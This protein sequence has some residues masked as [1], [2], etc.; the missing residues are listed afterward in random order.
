MDGVRGTDSATCTLPHRPLQSICPSALGASSRFMHPPA[1]MAPASVYLLSMSLFDLTHTGSCAQSCCCGGHGCLACRTSTS[2][3]RSSRWVGVG[4][5]AAGDWDGE[6]HVHVSGQL[7]QGRGW[8]AAESSSARGCLDVGHLQ[9]GKVG[10]RVP[11]PGRVP[12]RVPW[13]GQG[14]IAP[15]QDLP[16]GRDSRWLGQGGA[17]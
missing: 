11:W 16:G 13:Q 2:W 10:A 7:K 14:A 12:S 15:G 3:A 5:A 1:C 9:L 4:R 8:M 6:D 17:R